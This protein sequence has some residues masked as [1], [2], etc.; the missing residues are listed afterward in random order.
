M[1]KH[2]LPKSFFHRLTT[3]TSEVVGSPLGLFWAVTVVMLWAIA[4]PIFKFSDIW[5]EVITTGIAIVNFLMIF[6]IKNSQNHDSKAVQIK[7][8]ELIRS[9]DSAR[10]E[11]ISIEKTSEKELQ[12]IDDDFFRLI[13]I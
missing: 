13:L 1:Q 4:G 12:R 6:L 9:M 5:R 8:D 3:K 7:L 10:N 2:Q 11:I